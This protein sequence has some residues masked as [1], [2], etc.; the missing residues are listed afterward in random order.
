MQ[1][2]VDDNVMSMRRCFPPQCCW[3]LAVTRQSCSTARISWLETHHLETEGQG[4]A[5]NPHFWPSLWFHSD[6]IFLRLRF[7]DYRRPIRYLVRLTSDALSLLQISP[8]PGMEEAFRGLCWHAHPQRRLVFF[9]KALMETSGQL[10]QKFSVPVSHLLP[11]KMH[12]KL[13]L[14]KYNVIYTS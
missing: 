13:L 10:C 7:P 5:K 2:A 8:S 12:L 9:T 1:R 4:S 11:F 6:A 3:S 14:K